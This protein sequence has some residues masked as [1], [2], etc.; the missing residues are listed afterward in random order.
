MSIIVKH[1]TDLDTV[2]ERVG[3]QLGGL[4][5]ATALRKHGLSRRRA[6]CP[7]GCSSWPRSCAPR[8][9]PSARSELLDAFAA[10]GEVSWTQRRRRQGG[11]G[12]DAGQVARRTAASSTS[13]SSA[14]SSARAEAEALEHGISEQDAELDAGGAQIDLDAAARAHRPGHPRGRRRRAARP[15]PPGHRGLRAPGRGLGRHRRRRAAHPPRPGAAQR[16]CAHARAQ[17]VARGEALELPR[18]ALRR[19][20]AHLRRELERDAIERTERAAAVAA[21]ERAR[22]RAA[23]RPAAGPGRRAP[24]RRAAQAPPGH[25]GPRAPA[26]GASTRPS[27]C[28]ARCARRC[29][30]AAC[31]WSSSSARGGRAVPRSTC[32]ATCAPR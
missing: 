4:A 31:P 6:G 27:T 26:G 24:R 13:S 3:V 19:F 25:P 10:L 32:S 11:A 30:P 23:Q 5:G 12:G 8:A 28:A 7:R 9:W 21:A 15:R 1:R 2:A 22:P 18:E 20:E 16:R 17:A 29:R 14:S